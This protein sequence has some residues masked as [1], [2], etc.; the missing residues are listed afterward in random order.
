MNILKMNF[1]IQGKAARN[2]LFRGLADEN[3]NVNFL[4]YYPGPIIT[5][6]LTEYLNNVWDSDCR[7]WAKRDNY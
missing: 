2:A 7:N 5:R 1:Q 3:P 4:S 6:M